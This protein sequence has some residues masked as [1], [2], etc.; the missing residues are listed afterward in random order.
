MSLNQTLQAD[1]WALIERTES[2]TGYVS[3]L[4]SIEKGFRVLR[5]DHSLLGGQW[6]MIQGQKASEPI[7]GVF[8]MLEAVRLIETKEKPADKDAQALVM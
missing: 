4:E 6:V 1:N 7:Y 5:C 8:V 3:V 2:V